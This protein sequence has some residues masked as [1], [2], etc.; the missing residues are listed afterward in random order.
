PPP[1]L[2]F[3][4]VA[5][6]DYVSLSPQLAQA[7]FIGDGRRSTISGSLCQSIV[8]PAGA[9][10]LFLGTMDGFEWNNNSGSYSVSICTTLSS[11][12]C[13]QDDHNGNVL[14]FNPATGEYL[15]N[16][17][18]AAGFTVGGRG[19]ITFNGCMVELVH[20]VF[21]RIVIAKLDTCLRRGSA[22]VSST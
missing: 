13:L 17:C 10:R 15:F 16:A 18:K 21:D 19:V 6:R 2:D 20:S 3:G 5:S 8:V 9:A 12:L 1:S 7:F 22:S 11:D 14:R 4:T